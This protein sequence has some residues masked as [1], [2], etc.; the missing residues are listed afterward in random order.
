MNYCTRCGRQAGAGA[1]FCIG[2]GMPLGPADDSA[3]T[4]G[5]ADVPSASGLPGA[6]SS[7]F[8]G[9]AGW[10]LPG[11]AG[12][13][14][15]APGWAGGHVRLIDEV[16]ATVTGEVPLQAH[17]EVPLPPSGERPPWAPDG[18]LAQPGG[19]APPGAV[20]GQAD[21][22][23]PAFLSPDLTP[24]DPAF[25]SP[26][27]TPADPASFS[28]DPGPGPDAG[29]DH[30]P[31]EDTAAWPPGFAAQEPALGLPLRRPPRPSR[32][33]PPPPP[34][35]R[36]PLWLPVPADGDG[37]PAAAREPGSPP[38]EPEPGSPPAE[39]SP[40]RRGWLA[41][42]AVL[43]ALAGGLAAWHYLGGSRAGAPAGGQSSRSAVAPGAQR[44]PGRPSS[45]RPS[46][47][48]PSPSSRTSG[49]L[50]RSPGQSHRATGR[51][52]V[53]PGPAVAGQR[54]AHPVAAFLT[55]YFAAINDHDYPAFS[56]LFEPG[57]SPI[58]SAAEFRSGFRRSR[59]S[60]AR[61]VSLEQTA[62]GDWAASVA[63][64]SHQ[65]PGNSASHT[66]CTAWGVTFYL[67]PVGNSYLIGP[68]PPGYQASAH[69][70]G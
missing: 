69:P 41:P 6:A 22:A 40:R 68:P 70:C 32:A 2:C 54:V 66:A 3:E 49:A 37:Y 7:G 36:R 46:S 17:G 62:G 34:P 38:A 8:P 59:D 13:D 1:A 63:F 4:P 28:L 20:P 60:T 47:A 51:G 12:D 27:L 64:H 44:A 5:P 14:G 39:P 23:D 55:Q 42:V 57:A 43:A 53:I 21:P 31:S 58:R 56:R 26:D 18:T 67:V 50:G 33:E 16:P 35:P 19:E 10:G 45:A 48:R 29:Y 9:A 30:S 65:D 52:R 24:A 25:L 15:E 11:A 61:L